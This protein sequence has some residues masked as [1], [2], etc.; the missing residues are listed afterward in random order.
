MTFADEIAQATTPTQ[1]DRARLEAKADDALRKAFAGTITSHLNRPLISL[2]HDL[3]TNQV[4]WM[5]LPE[6]PIQREDRARFD[7]SDRRIVAELAKTPAADWARLCAGIGWTVVG[8]AALSWCAN[9]EDDV[10]WE[11]W[12]QVAKQVV[13]R[14]DVVRACR[15]SRP[16]C[17]AEFASLSELTRL[18]RGEQF[19]MAVMLAA[20]PDPILV[21]LD[22]SYLVQANAQ[23]ASFLLAADRVDGALPGPSQLGVAQWLHTVG[24]TIFDV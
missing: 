11:A 13:P 14:P 22:E 7:E 24:G 6:G 16:G 18:N 5:R 17:F 10:L 9:C 4:T 23:L 8:C 20:R 15:L 12:G 3:H 21:D 2:W 1:A 19:R